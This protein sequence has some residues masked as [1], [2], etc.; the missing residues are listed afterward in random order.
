MKPSLSLRLH[1]MALV[2]RLKSQAS[3]KASLRAAVRGLWQ[4]TT[5]ITQFFEMF[6]SAIDRGFE[7]A[8]AEGMR[9]VGLSMAD[10]T[11]EEREALDHMKIEERQYIF[12]FGLD[13]EAADKASGAALEPHLKRVELWV[14]RYNNLRNQAKQMAQNDPL[15]E[16]VRHA[17]ESCTSCIKLSGQRRRSSS[18]TRFGVR[19][20]SPGLECMCGAGGVDVCKCEFVPAEGHATRGRLPGWRV[21]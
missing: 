2:K 14:K 10:I 18:W 20:Q 16:W 11:P 6:R 8:W 15:L 7:Q 13:I 17:E 5:D 9:E 3:Y 4:G 19:P 21:C 12:P 1:Q